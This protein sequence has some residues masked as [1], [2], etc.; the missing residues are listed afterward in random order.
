MKRKC[1][2]CKSEITVENPPVLTVTAAG[3]PRYLCS[4]C[5][6]DFDEMT[7]SRELETIS[8]AMDRIGDKIKE[9]EI[10]DPTVLDAVDEIMNDSK[11][12]AEQIENGTYDFE[13]DIP[14]EE[15][16]EELFEISEEE[17]ELDRVEEEKNKK[18][19]KILN[20]VYIAVIAAVLCFVAYRVISSYL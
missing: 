3:S 16:P 10:E 7:S 20:I 14:E 5:D 2:I 1:S 12:R 8:K 19:D 15:I 18:I 6:A 11:T 4:D 17:K 9:F 13:S